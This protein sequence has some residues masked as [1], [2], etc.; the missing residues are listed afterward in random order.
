MSEVDEIIK[1]SSGWLLKVFLFY[2]PKFNEKTEKGKE[3]TNLS[4]SEK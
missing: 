2:F 4:E 1:L 3:K